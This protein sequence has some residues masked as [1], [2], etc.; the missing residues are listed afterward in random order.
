M[1]QPPPSGREPQIP[2][3]DAEAMIKLMD[4][5]LAIQ[6]A[7]LAT[8]KQKAGASATRWGALLVV[9]LLL[10]GIMVWGFS[11][12]QAV[13]LETPTRPPPPSPAPARR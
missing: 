4:Q 9:L 12:L 5:E 1:N 8:N 3:A 11:K 10:L 7:K 2:R 6:R 13:K